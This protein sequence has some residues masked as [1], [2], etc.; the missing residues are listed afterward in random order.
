MKLLEYIKVIVIY[1]Y[2]E[3][4]EKIRQKNSQSDNLENKI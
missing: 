4:R 1:I 2:I 3:L